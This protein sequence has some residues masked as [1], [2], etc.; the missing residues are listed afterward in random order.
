MLHLGDDQRAVRGAG[1]QV[2]FAHAA[3]VVA[4]QD[5]EALGFEELRRSQL[6]PGTQF[7]GTHRAGSRLQPVDQGAAG[8]NGFGTTAADLRPV[9]LTLDASARGQVQLACEA[10]QRK[11]RLPRTQLH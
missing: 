10:L 8:S 4:Q 5:G 1:N 3:A 6:G 9:Q 11:C 7:A 2:Q